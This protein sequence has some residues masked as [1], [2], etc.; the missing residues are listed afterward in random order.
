MKLV[1]TESGVEAARPIRGIDHVL[2]GVRGLEAAYDTYQ[3]LGFTLS[4]RGRHIGWGTANYCVM[5][6]NDY[7][8]LLGIIDSSQFTNNLNRFL[9]S[10][11]G[12]LG[13]AFAS[14]DV[15]L[16]ARAL[17]RAGIQPG[18]MRDLKRILE[19]PEGEVWPRFKLLHL[20]P[21]A[22]PGT[23]AFVCQ[24]LTPELVWQKAWTEHANGAT[25]L[26]A[27]TSVVKDPSALAIPYAELFGFDRVRAGDGVVEVDCDGTW[28][29][30]TTSEMLGQL[31]PGL[32]GAPRPP[33]PWL[34]AL[35]IAVE[36]LARTAT[37]LEHAGLPVH[38]DGKQV[39]RLPPAAACGVLLEFAEAA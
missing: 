25:G 13:L 29:R 8:E 24:H 37:L 17:H 28:L 6:P 3:R 38:W 35:R 20:P 5:F 4:P 19:D 21:E 10:R 16:A 39:L 12:L 32:A 2:V 1:V 15:G 23:S 9:E 22:T 11:E 14:D 30:F 27:M 33:T 31:H 34:A 26:I 18:D 7:I 36:D